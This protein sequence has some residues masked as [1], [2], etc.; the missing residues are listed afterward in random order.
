MLIRM[1]KLSVTLLVQAIFATCLALVPVVLTSGNAFAE[2]LENVQFS[3]DSAKAFPLVS[4]TG[5]R[6]KHVAKLA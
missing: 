2:S 3:R 6:A 4:T 5:T 1:R